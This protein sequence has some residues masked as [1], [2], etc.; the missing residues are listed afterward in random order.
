MFAEEVSHPQNGQWR[1][2]EVPIETT[3]KEPR[4]QRGQRWQGGTVTELEEKLVDI[5]RECD[6]ITLFR[7]LF[8]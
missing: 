2:V 6:T 7:L 5:T 8:I 3:A 1:T 4:L